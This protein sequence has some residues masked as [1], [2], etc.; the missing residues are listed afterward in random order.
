MTAN[1]AK[2]LD[3]KSSRMEHASE[4]LE[5][6]DKKN[7]PFKEVPVN[8]MYTSE[9]IEHGHGSFLQGVK[10]FFKMVLKSLMK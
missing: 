9:I 10:V 7:I 6:I 8:V 3:F 1:A 2:K 4:I 5:L